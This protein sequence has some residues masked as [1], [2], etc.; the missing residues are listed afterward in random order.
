[1]PHVEN[2]RSHPL[3]FRHISILESF[4]FCVGRPMDVEKQ[5]MDGEKG[6][7]KLNALGVSIFK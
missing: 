3:T 1:M 6:K 5:T 7:T 2:C 4:A